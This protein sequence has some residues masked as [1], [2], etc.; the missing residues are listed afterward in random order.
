MAK[1]LIIEVS[2]G[3]VEAVILDGVTLPEDTICMVVDHDTEAADDTTLCK[4]GDAEVLVTPLDI[5]QADDDTSRNARQ[6]YD[7]WRLT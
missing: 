3:I 5:Q 2:C 7:D 1:R 4:Y 6:A